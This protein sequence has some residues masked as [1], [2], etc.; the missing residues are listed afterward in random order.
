MS[1]EG[2]QSCAFLLQQLEE[3]EHYETYIMKTQHSMAL[4]S[5]EEAFAIWK[6]EQLQRR[7]RFIQQHGVAVTL[8]KG[9]HVPFWQWWMAK[10]S[11]N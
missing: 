4:A 10:L 9:Y 3:K 2:D 11:E 7:K 6:K 1:D 8:E 5:I